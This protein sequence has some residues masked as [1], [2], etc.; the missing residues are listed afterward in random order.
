MTTTGIRAGNGTTQVRRRQG[1]VEGPRTGTRQTPVGDAFLAPYR[2]GVDPHPKSS[3]K[4]PYPSRPFFTGCA[5][6]SPGRRFE[7]YRCFR[8][9]YSSAH[10]PALRKHQQSHDGQRPFTCPVCARSF[11]QRT[12]LMDH[13]RIHTGE[14]PFR[15]DLCPLAFTQKSVLTRHVRT[16]AAQAP[17]PPLDGPAWLEGVPRVIGRF[18]CPLC[19][20]NFKQKWNLSMHLHTHTGERPFKCGYCSR[21]FADRS[22]MRKHM[23]IHTRDWSTEELHRFLC[24]TQLQRSSEQLSWQ[25]NPELVSGARLTIQPPISSAG[26]SYGESPVL[27]TRL[28]VGFRCNVCGHATLQKDHVKAHCRTHTGEKPYACEWCPRRFGQHCNLARHRRTH[29]GER[30]YACPLCPRAFAEKAKM[31]GHLKTHTKEKPF[32]CAV[33]HHRFAYRRGLKEHMREHVHQR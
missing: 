13:M 17:L 25:I 9:G 23:F 7:R 18:P 27:W 26:P 30:P 3:R 28:G 33:C 5:A 11:V 21:A 29:T 4:K 10:W 2:R 31:Q 14:R 15:C 8:C 24:S 1:E 20:M 16:H 22:N 32:E 19:P 12:H 6:A